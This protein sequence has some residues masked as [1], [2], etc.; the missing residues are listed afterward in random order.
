MQAGDGDAPGFP[1][2]FVLDGSVD[3]GDVHQKAFVAAVSRLD[4]LTNLQRAGG[5]VGDVL[6]ARFRALDEYL[7]VWGPLNIAFGGRRYCLSVPCCRAVGGHWRP[8][9]RA[10]MP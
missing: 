10:V 1:G 8:T 6:S 2:A 7:R 9:A 4:E 3:P 5:D